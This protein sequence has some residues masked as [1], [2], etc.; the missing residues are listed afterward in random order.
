[1]SVKASKE[2]ELLRNV[3]SNQPFLRWIGV[4]LIDAGPGWAREKLQIRPEF[5]QP[6]VVHG[7]VT[8]TLA[9]TLTA[10]AVLTLTYPKEWVTTVEQ[11]INFVRAVKSGSIVGQSR[12][13]H[14]GNRIAVCEAEIMNDADQIV[15]KSTATLMRLP[16]TLTS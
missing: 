11:K 5:F 9:D 6:H 16:Q 10:H 3:L 7:G 13:V 15:A 14:M 12:L 2:F 1:M 4:E 8:Y